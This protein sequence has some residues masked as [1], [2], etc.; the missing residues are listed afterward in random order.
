MLDF[1]ASF[2]TVPSLM[3]FVFSFFRFFACSVSSPLGGYRYAVNELLTQKKKA[4]C[5]SIVGDDGFVTA[6]DQIG[7]NKDNPGLNTTAYSTSRPV[8]GAEVQTSSCTSHRFIWRKSI[9]R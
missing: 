5:L 1:A 6:L 8:V 7:R 9:K 3:F 2:L 4:L